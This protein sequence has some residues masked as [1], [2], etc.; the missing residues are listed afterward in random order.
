[1]WF[2]ITARD[3]SEYYL[4]EV[5]P[6]NLAN[7]VVR[8]CGPFSVTPVIACQRNQCLTGLVGGCRGSVA[9]LQVVGAIGCVIYRKNFRNG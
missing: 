4:Y 7:S 3:P 2:G 5:N 8:N 6:L 9:V 1:V